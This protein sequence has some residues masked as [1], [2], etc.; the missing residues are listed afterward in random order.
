MCEKIEHFDWI[1]IKPLTNT[2]NGQAIERFYFCGDKNMREKREYKTANLCEFHHQSCFANFKGKKLF[3][4]KVRELFLK[5]LTREDNSS[6]FQTVMFVSVLLLV[7]FASAADIINVNPCGKVAPGTTRFVRDFASCDS[8]FWC[9][10][11]R[12]VPT[13]RCPAGQIFLEDEQGC[14]TGTDCDDC[15]AEGILAV[16]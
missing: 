9:D 15:P 4:E 5:I 6:I 10:G 13:D 7:A 3:S 11:T 14:D 16:R 8:V 2:T 12:T 1:L